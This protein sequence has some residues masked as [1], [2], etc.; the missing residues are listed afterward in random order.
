MVALRFSQARLW[1]TPVAKVR[2]HLR[3]ARGHRWASAQ[4]MGSRGV[5][6]VRTVRCKDTVGA[7]SARG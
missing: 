5:S 7:D 6:G 2:G 4:V 1:P 3:R